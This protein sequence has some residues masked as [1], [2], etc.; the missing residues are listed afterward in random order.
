MTRRRRIAFRLG[1]AAVLAAGLVGVLPGVVTAEGRGEIRPALDRLPPERMIEVLEPDPV[2]APD[3]TTDPAT[4]GRYEGDYLLT[5]EDGTEWLVNVSLNGD[6]L[7][8]SVQDPDAPGVALTSTLVQ[9]YLDTFLFDG[10]GDG[11][12]ETDLTFCDR[13]GAPGFTMWM[14]NRNAVGERRLTPRRGGRL[15]T[16]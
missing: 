4:W 10:N 12:P 14:R 16:Q 3:L 6:T 13:K 11:T 2:E 15:V 5:E 9:L 8:G 7:V 1:P